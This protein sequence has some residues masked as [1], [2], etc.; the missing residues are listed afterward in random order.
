VSVVHSEYV[1]GASLK[2][3][4]G[5]IFGNNDEPELTLEK[6][7]LILH[8]A[9]AGIYNA[10]IQTESKLNHLRSQIDNVNSQSTFSSHMLKRTAIIQHRY[11]QH[12][13]QLSDELS[14][15]QMNIQL[16]KCQ[17]E[18]LGAIRIGKSSLENY[19]G[20]NT[21][22]AVEALF[23]QTEDAIVHISDISDVISTSDTAM[24]EPSN[25]LLT[26][27]K[28]EEEFDKLFKITT[29]GNTG[30]SLPQRHLDR[31][32]PMSYVVE[33]DKTKIIDYGTTTTVVPETQLATNSMPMATIV[34]EPTV[35]A[36][37]IPVSPRPL[38]S[39]SSPPVPV[40]PLSSS[41]QACTPTPPKVKNVVG[42]TQ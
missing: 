30:K 3:F 5:T 22:D 35:G 24:R 17:N 11:I 18:T 27:D 16:A 41:T 29:S 13:L 20:K 33:P 2:K 4:A 21:I 39:T 42:N 15:H 36:D 40:S 38:P 1:M 34:S 12:L 19:A 9:H 23:N 14:K 25:S 8:N 10:I 7:D 28:V 6:A 32:N 31:F 37:V 26:S